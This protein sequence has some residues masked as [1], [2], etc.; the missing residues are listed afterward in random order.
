[1]TLHVAA[2]MSVERSAIALGR[3][4][5]Y[6]LLVTVLSIPPARVSDV[7]Q[8]GDVARKRL[9]GE[10]EDLRPIRPPDDARSHIRAKEGSRSDRRWRCARSH[11]DDVGASFGGP[12][13]Q[14]VLQLGPKNLPGNVDAVRSNYPELTW[15]STPVSASP[16]GSDPDPS[17]QGLTPREGEVLGLLI[18]GHSA[19]AISSKLGIATNTARSHIQNILAKLH[20]RTGLEAVAVLTAGHD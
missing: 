3:L 13:R 1:M 9:S 7:P 10:T 5:L 15:V 8:M 11:G 19:V 2:T 17:P 14:E 18:E 20:V 16:A 4:P 12:S 6:D